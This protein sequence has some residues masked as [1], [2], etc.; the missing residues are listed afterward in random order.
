MDHDFRINY[1][2]ICRNGGNSDSPIFG[3]YCGSVFP[4]VLKSFSNSIYLKFVTD[5]SYAEKGFEIQW[6]SVATGCGG[7]LS[8]HEG[9]ISS[10][11]YPLPYDH[12][13]KCIYRITVNLGSTINIVFTDL[14]MEKRWS[15]IDTVEV[16]DG[17]TLTSLTKGQI[18]NHEVPYNLTTTENTAIVIFESDLSDSGRGFSLTYTTNCNRKLKGFSGVIESP[19][20]PNPYPHHV[21]CV[22]TIDVP[23]GNKLGLEFSHFDLEMSYFSS[24][25]EFDYLEIDQMDGETLLEKK[26]YCSEK[27]RHMEVSAKSVNIRFHSDVSMSESGFRLEWRV[28]G[29]GNEL[30]GSGM[31][32]ESNTDR[33]N[34][35]QCDWK[36]STSIGKQVELTILHFQYDNAGSCIDEGLIVSKEGNL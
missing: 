2:F 27:P 20:F 3:R 19:N 26:R 31:I 7:L 16:M 12:D 21:D 14:D 25:C 17:S 24:S 18:C 34:P 15:C 29:C 9:S 5:Y 28:Q 33:E 22:W 1:K 11:N 13:S 23:L 8:S 30:E 4:T 32:R 10:P 35:I 6:E 36:I